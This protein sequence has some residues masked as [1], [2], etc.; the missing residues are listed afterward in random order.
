MEAYKGTLESGQQ[1]FV[2]QPKNLGKGTSVFMV[3]MHSDEGT[4]CQRVLMQR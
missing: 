4:K 1:K 3:K 2:W